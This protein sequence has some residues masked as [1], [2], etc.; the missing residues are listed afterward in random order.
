M[1]THYADPVT[2]VEH[3]NMATATRFI[4]GFNNDDWDTVREVVAPGYVFHHPL[5]G[6]VTAGPDGMVATWAGFKQLSPDSW[7]PIPVMIAERDYVAVLLPTYGTFTGSAEKAPLPTGG[8]LDYGMVNIV[9]LE[10]GKLCEMWF[11]MDPLV[12]MQQMGVAPPAPTRQLSRQAQANLA[13]F[14]KMAT[15]IEAEYDTVAAFDDA[16]VVMAPPQA[17]KATARRWMEVYTFESRSPELVY[18]HELVTQPPYGGNPSVAKEVS[19]GVVERWFDKVLVGHSRLAV[20]DMVSPHVVV[21]PTAMPCE[22]GY[23][24]VDGVIQW[25]DEHWAAFGELTVA[26]DFAVAHGEMVAV[27]WTAHGTSLGDFM[28]QAPTGQP[29]GF[30]GISMYRIEHGKVAEIWETRNTLG[31][32][33]QLNPEIG[34]GQ[35][36]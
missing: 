34:G 11:G 17:D 14:Q 21:H 32:L 23:Y 29:I 36:H 31:I 1:A 27:R 4:E 6:T 3:A 26:G 35:H 7:H 10:N 18:S 25:L 15:T 13:A 5:G 12:E 8:R 20:A 22:S 2:D 33:H 16:V 19:R 9:R 30:G 28:G 24:G